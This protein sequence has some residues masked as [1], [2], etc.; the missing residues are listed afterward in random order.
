MPRSKGSKLR[1]GNL[2]HFREKRRHPGSLARTSF[3]DRDFRASTA[4]GLAG[5]EPNTDE[6]WHP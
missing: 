2:S 4:E 1:D 6:Q 5:K 3:G